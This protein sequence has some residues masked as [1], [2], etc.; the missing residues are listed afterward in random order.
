M[1]VSRPSVTNPIAHYT[2]I[3]CE[4][5]GTRDDDENHYAVSVRDVPPTGTAFPPPTFRRY[6]EK[7]T[8]SAS[9]D[10]AY[11]YVTLS[12]AYWPRLTQTLL[13]ATA[14]AVAWW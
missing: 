2:S 9:C 3:R 8:D 5:T 13:K 7:F 1:G 12:C 11:G 6:L 14:T 10:P 4:C